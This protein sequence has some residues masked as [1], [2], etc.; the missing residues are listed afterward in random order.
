MDDFLK[1]ECPNCGQPI[2][3]PSEGTGQ[4]VPC[5][6]CEKPVTLK[7]A[8]PPT[9]F[10]S[11]VI[12]PAPTSTQKPKERK[13]V[14]TNLLKLTEETIRVKTQTGDTPLHRAAKNGRIYEIPRHLLQLELFLAKNNS[15]TTPLHFA[16]TYGHLDQVP[17]EFLTKE[18][19]T[20]STEYQNKESKTGPTPPR[21]ETP[22]SRSQSGL[23]QSPGN[24]R[25][26]G[27]NPDLPERHAR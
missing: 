5:P 6:A 17:P 16:A 26:N 3:Y 7:P 12:P 2:E 20:A 22:F 9:K 23:L 13:P 27:K 1:C 8:S 25:S 15:G 19:L 18:T 14:R 10:G 4:T 11:V 24:G 21:T